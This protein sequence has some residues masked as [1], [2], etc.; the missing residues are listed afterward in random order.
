M[1]IDEIVG[2]DKPFVGV[3]IPNPHNKE[4]IIPVVSWIAVPGSLY[5]LRSDLTWYCSIG[6]SLHGMIV[7]PDDYHVKIKV[8]FSDVSSQTEVIYEENGSFTTGE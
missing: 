8:K 2:S 6:T 7:D 4:D 1:Y 3:G 5:E